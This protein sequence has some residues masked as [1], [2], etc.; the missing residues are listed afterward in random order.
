MKHLHR[1]AIGG[2]GLLLLAGAGPAAAADPVGMWTTQDGKARVR[3]DH[4]G[5]A[6]CGS[7][8]W[9]REPNDPA[10]GRPKTDKHNGDAARRG[11]P[12]VGVQI[13][14]QMK[15]SGTGRWSGQV[16]NAEDGKTY[17]GHITLT[18]ASVLTLEGCALGGLV[19]KSQRWS[20][21]K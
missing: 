6:L 3:I 4:C 21:T 8:V 12:L 7:I 14:Q 19:C 13:L 17:S 1:A 15:A 9:L 5:S 11:R 20:R 10:T 2:V 16:Y 18:G